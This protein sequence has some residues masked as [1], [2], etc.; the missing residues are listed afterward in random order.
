MQLTACNNLWAGYYVCVH[1]P[2]L[3]QP[4]RPRSHW[5]REW[6]PTAR[7]S[8]KLPVAKAAIRLTSKQA[9][10]W[11]SSAHGTKIQMR[12]VVTC[13]RV[14]MFVSAF[15]TCRIELKDVPFR[16]W[17]L[18]RPSSQILL[19]ADK[20][21][22]EQDCELDWPG[23][24]SQSIGWNLVANPLAIWYDAEAWMLPRWTTM[25]SVFSESRFV[26]WWEESMHPASLLN[27]RI[28]L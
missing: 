28:V 11:I 9:S 19:A 2:G 3:L 7:A 25:I 21:H 23:V 12:L 1:V 10:H 18:L 22:Y 20:A 14:T 16:M 24:Q 17:F 5:C 15:K 6:F 13:G 26:R 4:P 8:I 27:T